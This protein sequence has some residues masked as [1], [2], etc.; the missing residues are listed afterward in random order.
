MPSTR[1]ILKPMGLALLAAAFGT[2][3]TVAVVRLR[4]APAQAVAAL[5]VAAPSA[6]VVAAPGTP[7]LVQ[8]GDME[9]GADAP[10]GWEYVWAGNAAEMNRL[11][12]VRD[13]AQKGSGTASLRLETVGDKAA[14]GSVSQDLTGLKP[15]QTVTIKA[16]GRAEGD[17][18]EAFIAL[19]V[20]DPTFKKQYSFDAVMT[21]D[22]LMKGAGFDT[23]S[24][25]ITLPTTPFVARV[26]VL[27]GGRGKIWADD[28]SVS[29]TK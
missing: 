15:G 10:T 26:V 16:S 19:Q 3:A 12:V 8:N 21:K 23:E 29:A 25:E 14:Y 28:I 6:P 20:F 22:H 4:Q 11:R 5:R 9:A 24:R 7:P 18:S 17:L 2:L 1:I 13:T 27:I